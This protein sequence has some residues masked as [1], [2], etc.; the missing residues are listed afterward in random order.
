ML[1]NATELVSLTTINL[2]QPGIEYSDPGIHRIF[3]VLSNN[4]D[5]YFSLTLTLLLEYV[6]FFV[7]NFSL[8]QIENPDSATKT[9]K[10]DILDNAST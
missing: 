3:N 10:L 1:D 2:K 8:T 7:L 6:P 4:S 9:S 5:N